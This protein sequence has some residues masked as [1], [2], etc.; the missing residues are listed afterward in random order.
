MLKRKI[1]KARQLFSEGFLL[2][3]SLLAG[4][5]SIV[6]T[7]SLIV[8]LVTIIAT[9]FI[10]QAYGERQAK[11]RL[12]ELIDSMTPMASVAGFVKDATLAKETAQGFIRNSDVQGV[13]IIA[14]GHVLA[15]VSRGQ[16][17]RGDD[18]NRNAIVRRLYS[19]FDTTE[20]I[21]S[22]VVEPNW[23]SIRDKVNESVRQAATVL[24]L[25]ASSM[26]AV[27]ALVVTYRIVRPFK[28][29]ADATHHLDAASGQMLSVPEVVWVSLASS[30]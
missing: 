9:F 5:L 17:D 19:P 7:I 23:T 18:E 30:V 14:E 1:E 2:K 10:M 16:A 4:A 3:R 20:V 22:I 29:I 12:E 24:V 11:Q 21:G 25:L 15:V 27:L 13:T 28:A 6:G 8:A 26:F